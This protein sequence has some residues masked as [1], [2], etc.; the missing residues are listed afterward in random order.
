MNRRNGREAGME[1]QGWKNP[2]VSLRRKREYTM[3]EARF[4]REICLGSDFCFSQISQS[5]LGL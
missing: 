3:E 4:R 5:H 2:T 1:N